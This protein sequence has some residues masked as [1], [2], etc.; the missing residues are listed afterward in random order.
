MKRNI[1]DIFN[2][3]LQKKENAENDLI[4][5]SRRKYPSIKKM[6]QLQGEIEAYQDTI[7]LIE[8]SDILNKEVK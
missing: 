5:E 4:G 3:L 2:L 7:T 8:T 6:L 1:N